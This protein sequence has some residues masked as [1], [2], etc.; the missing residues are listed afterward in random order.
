MHSWRTQRQN[1]IDVCA[2]NIE[3]KF[4]TSAWYEYSS[5]VVHEAE[6]AGEFIPTFGKKKSFEILIKYLPLDK[7]VMLNK[8]IVFI[9][10]LI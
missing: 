3:Q 1:P 2:V 4:K 10:Q 6:T 8:N 9:I 5:F 7:D